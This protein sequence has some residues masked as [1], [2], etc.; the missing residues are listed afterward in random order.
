[1]RVIIAAVGALLLSISSAGATPFNQWSGSLSI[2]TMRALGDSSVIVLFDA[3]HGFSCTVT[4]Q[5]LLD[6]ASSP[7]LNDAKLSMLLTAMTAGKQVKII[8][9]SCTTSGYPKVTSVQIIN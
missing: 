9:G 3:S 8:A 4:N 1:M 2:L 6:P 5:G 7:T